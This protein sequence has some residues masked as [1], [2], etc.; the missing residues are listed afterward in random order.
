[1]AEERAFGLFPRPAKCEALL[2]LRESHGSKLFVLSDQRA[3]QAK[4]KRQRMAVSHESIEDMSDR[5]TVSSSTRQISEPLHV[6]C[7]DR[8]KGE[9]REL[10]SVEVIDVPRWYVIH[11]HIR[12][13]SR[14]ESNLRVLEVGTYNPQIQERRYNHFTGRPTNFRKPLFP[15]YIFA[16]F[17][18]G[19]LLL[20]VMST[21]GVRNVLK[22]G[23]DPVPLEDEI[24]DFIKSR[25]QENDV[26]PI[27]DILQ[28]GDEVEIKSGPL[29]KLVGIFDKEISGS[30]RVIILL[31]AVSFQGNVVIGREQVGK[32]VSPK[33]GK[34]GV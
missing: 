3:S 1:M 8:I 29:Q 33:L 10:T 11:T 30:K 9:M 16:R 20:K 31:N 23:G 6:W 5:Y 15:Q 17:S 4:P 28:K 12:Q 26:V 13:E 24:I 25:Q 14:A 18:L 2:V 19:K 7:A 21:R 32:A 22:F 34:F 27:G